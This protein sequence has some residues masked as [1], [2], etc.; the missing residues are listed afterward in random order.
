VSRTRALYAWLLVVALVAVGVAALGR[1]WALLAL[2]AVPAAV[3]PLRS[4]LAGA[5]GRALLPVLRDTGRL[6]LVYAVLLGIGVAL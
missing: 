3:P 2:G 1:P 6:E 4:V 5:T